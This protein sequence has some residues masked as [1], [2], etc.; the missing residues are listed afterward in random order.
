MTNFHD[1]MGRFEHFAQNFHDL[2]GRFEHF[3]QVSEALSCTWTM[4]GLV[5]LTRQTQSIQIH[6][7]SSLPTAQVPTSKSESCRRFQNI[8]AHESMFLFL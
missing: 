3:A 4:I 8:R 2:M 7:S 1:L 6:P 5:A